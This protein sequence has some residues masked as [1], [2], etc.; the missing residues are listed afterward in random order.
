M[1]L[2][3]KNLHETIERSP[4]RQAGPSCHDQVLRCSLSNEVWKVAKTP[5]IWGYL[6]PITIFNGKIHYKWP[7]SIAMFNY[8]RVILWS[9]KVVGGCWWLVEPSWQLHDLERVWPPCHGRN[10]RG[11]RE[12]GRS[13]RPE[14]DRKR[15]SELPNQEV[16][17]WLGRGW[18]HQSLKRIL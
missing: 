6:G 5:R 15:I 17:E 11:E 2:W 12:D 3:C 7:F 13:R 10:F 8:Q 18:A 4:S 1:C 16:W 14:A 9:S